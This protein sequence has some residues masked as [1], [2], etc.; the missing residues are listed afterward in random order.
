MKNTH[1]PPA[2]LKDAVFYQIYPQSFYD[3][4][5][6]GI[7][8]LPGIIAKLDYIQSLGVT[9]LWLNPIFTSPFG[10]AGYDISDFYQVAPRYGTNRDL[11]RLCA[12]A[13]RRGMRVCLD[14]VAGHSSNQHPWFL[15]S[16][17]PEKNKYSDWYVWTDS[18]W[19]SETG[20]V[21]GCSERDG[22]YL[23]NFFCFQPALNYGHAKPDP[24]KK[25]QLPVTHPAVQAVRRELKN[26]MKFWLDLGA[27][28]FRVDM[29]SSL[30]RGDADG[31]GLREL[32]RFYRQWLDRDY[33]EA[34]LISEW[35]NPRRAIGSGFDIDF[36]IHFNEPAYYKLLG[37][38]WEAG[39]GVATQVFFD[40]QGRGDVAEFLSSYL[41]NFRATRGRGYI[42]LPTGNHDFP[43]HS[44][45][46]A[47]RDLRVIYA[48]L[49]TMPGVPF[50]YYGDEIGMKYL[51]N[52][53]SKEGSYQNRTGTRTPMQWDS[54]RNA[55]F[56]T[57]PP[58][59]LYLPVDG[60]AAAPTVARQER[61]PQSLL[62]LTRR[63]LVLRRRHPALGN[64]GD[65]RPVYAKKKSYPLVYE[66][67]LNGARCWVAVNPTNRPL[68]VT[69]PAV[70]GAEKLE[71]LDADL[72]KRGTKTTLT[73]KPVSFGI[74]SVAGT[75]GSAH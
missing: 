25:W 75:R 70:A 15:A 44:R 29:A 5:G 14:L 7:G 32:W 62:N 36:M 57:A 67:R 8:D 2:W 73:M 72:T 24:K 9:A 71:A 18:A 47:E 3:T 60:R 41:R 39:G 30:V 38:A 19:T 28:G 22:G 55:G 58:A 20:A 46:R 34:V 31:A 40:R 4:N 17:K 51:E 35:S 33:P 1:P 21:R 13:H 48:M 23:P 27:D 69:L 12:E 74:W 6:D 65:F 10:D 61:D 52:L 59:K 45:G 37:T 66:R 53:T 64:T 63:L 50:I 49:F 54:A 43:R 11:Q 42:S 68:Q 56:S 16:A 26:I